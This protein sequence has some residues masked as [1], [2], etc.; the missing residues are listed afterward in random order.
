[1]NKKIYI[2][3]VL[4]WLV[5]WAAKGQSYRFSDKPEEFAPDVAKAMASTK[6]ERLTTLGSGFETAWSTLNEAQRTKVMAIA[7][8]MNAKK[9]RL[10]PILSNSSAR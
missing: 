7:Q 5:A 10:T 8:K 3:L 4:G 6:N 1:M 9:Y 2:V